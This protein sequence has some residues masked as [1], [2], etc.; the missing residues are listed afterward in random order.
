MQLYSQTEL[1]DAHE[2]FFITGR[3]IPPVVLPPNTTQ[4]EFDAL[5]KKLSSILGDSH[6]VSGSDLINFV[7]PFGFHQNYVP[8]AALW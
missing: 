2:S 1:Q 3:A 8:S 5:L 6:V 4:E 7:D